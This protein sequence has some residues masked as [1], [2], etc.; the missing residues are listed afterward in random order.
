MPVNNPKALLVSLSLFI[1][2]ASFTQWREI[3]RGNDEDNTIN[4][5]SFIN[6]STGF[7]AF[8]KFIGYTT[9]SGH[10]YLPRYVRYD[11]T[12]FNNFYGVNLTFGFEASGVH[13]FSSDSLVVFGD[14]GWEPAILFS[15]NQ[16]QTWKLVF[17]KPLNPSAPTLG[18]AVTNLKFQGNIGLAVHHEGILKSTNR[19]QTWSTVVNASN[20]LLQKL[21]FL[22]T[23]HALV[24]GGN[25]M[26]QTYDF[27][28]N[29]NNL[30]LPT[31]SSSDNYNNVFFLNNS[32]GY[33]SQRGTG[34]IYKTVTGG[35][36]W[37][38]M[39]EETIQGMN[40]TDMYFMNDS[41]GFITSEGL[42]EVY[43]TSDNGKTWER[44]KRNS[45]YQYLYYGMTGLF[46]YNNQIGW[47]CGLKG[48]LMIN[49][50]GSFPTFPRAGFKIDTSTMS[51]NNIVKL[52]NFSK[53]NYQYQWYKD[54]VPIGTSYNANYIHDRFK[55]RD[56]LKLIV[57]NGIDTDSLVL[58]QN[59]N[60]PA[61]P[62]I[63]S[64]APA[65]GSTGA[66]ILIK[67]RNFNSISSVMFG[68]VSASSFTLLSDTTIRAIIGNGATGSV[69]I[70]T[71]SGTISFPGFS[72]IPPPTAR[73]PVIT[74][75]SPASGSVGTTVTISGQ[76]FDVNSN[77]NIVYFGAVKAKVLSATVNSVTC[78]VPFGSSYSPISLL[79][80]TT[81]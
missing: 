5:A 37:T 28:T 78:T 43:K 61:L 38:K 64:F 65:E 62:A 17:H 59:F 33:I 20:S 63:A 72:F 60:L 39:N 51:S 23:G 44:C 27:G 57:S 10:T 30:P 36:F 26:Y 18:N 34:R 56:T 52:L 81:G 7:L 14:F 75:F 68:G 12:D 16:G 13:A 73:P 70:T 76:N 80:T 8:T 49:S 58:Y 15:A 19:G 21:S 40:G 54:G 46:F 67:G 45:D 79:N 48:Y 77:N 47:A 3:N 50:T 11:N 66:V 22:P 53:P 9:D 41:T 42:Y 31:S 69:S 71:T 2:T 1:S 55:A 35:V 4:G 6:P 25:K 32:T 74:S 29:W 24:I